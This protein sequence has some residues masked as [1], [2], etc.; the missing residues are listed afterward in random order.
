MLK[1][2]VFTHRFPQEMR[3]SASPPRPVLPAQLPVPPP[4]LA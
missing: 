2:L 3:A 1:E 4:L